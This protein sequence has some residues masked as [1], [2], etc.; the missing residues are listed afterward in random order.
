MEIDDEHQF[1]RPGIKCID[2][3]ASPGSWSQ[4][5][6]RR[7]FPPEDPVQGEECDFSEMRF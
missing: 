4:V 1:L 3:G 2:M 6:A 5:A 7:I